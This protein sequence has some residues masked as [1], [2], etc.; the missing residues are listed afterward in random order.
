MSN[1][2]TFDS[3]PLEMVALIIDLTKEIEMDVNAS[4]WD[5]VLLA[6]G[7]WASDEE[8]D[9]LF[10]SWSPL[11]HLLSGVPPEGLKNRLRQWV[12][13]RLSSLIT[14][15]ETKARGLLNMKWPFHCLQFLVSGK[16]YV[17]EPYT[18]IADEVIQAFVQ[19]SAVGRFVKR[20]MNVLPPPNAR[21]SSRSVQLDKMF[22]ECNLI[23]RKDVLQISR[24]LCDLNTLYSYR[25]LSHSLQ[26]TFLPI[27]RWI[28]INSI[29]HY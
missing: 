20:Y 14:T 27:R 18:C 11:H 12:L 25:I 17:L 4:A 6:A 8:G 24:I 23:Q 2:S 9:P 10:L 19:K 22:L 29:C 13:S 26:N 3:I 5:V 1:L 15:F 21:V 16:N 7:V 28:P